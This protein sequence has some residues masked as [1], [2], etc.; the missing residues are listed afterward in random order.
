MKSG[1]L[2]GTHS[3]ARAVD[4]SIV[5]GVKVD[6]LDRVRLDTCRKYCSGSKTNLDFSAS[7]MLNN[8]VSSMVGTSANDSSHIASAVVFLECCQPCLHES[9]GVRLTMEMASS[10]TSSNHTNSRLQPPPLQYTPSPTVLPMMTLRSVP[11]RSTTKAVS[12][13]PTMCLSFCTS[14]KGDGKGKRIVCTSFGLAVAG[15][16]TAVVLC[17]PS[18]EDLAGLDIDR[19]TNFLS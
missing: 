5:F 11:P 18:V 16:G 6:D 12:F 14:G 7:I 15:A 4:L 1:N 2:L 10:Q 3:S 19:R 17:P 13:S 9:V 8:L